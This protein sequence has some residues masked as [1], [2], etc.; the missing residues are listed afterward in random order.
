MTNRWNRVLLCAGLTV[1]LLT[2]K[3]LFSQAMDGNLVGLVIDASGAGVPE[4]DVSVVNI[5]TGVKFVGKTDSSGAYRFGNLLVGRYDLTASAT[6][7][8]TASFKQI[9]VELNKTTTL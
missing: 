3:N 2:N 1:T 9:A 5:D 7:F 4:A 8:T 6:G